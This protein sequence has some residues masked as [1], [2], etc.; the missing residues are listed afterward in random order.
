M[1]RDQRLL[2]HL[3]E[4]RVDICRR[5]RGKK[6]VRRRAGLKARRN[7]RDVVVGVVVFVTCKGEFTGVIV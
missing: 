6:E 5:A 7:I 4:G 2:E 3:L 1:G